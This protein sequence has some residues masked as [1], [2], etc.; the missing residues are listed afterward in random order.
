ME[1]SPPLTD[2]RENQIPWAEARTFLRECIATRHRPRD[3]ATLEDLTQ[4]ALVRL[5]RVIRREEV[6]NMNGLMYEIARRT[7][8][9]HI[10]REKRGGLL[11][12]RAQ[13]DMESAASPQDG[14][15]GDPLERLRFTILEYFRASR[16]PCH[17][18]ALVFFEGQDWK[19]VAARM[20]RPYT[21]IRKQWSRCIQVLRDAL[22]SNP[23]WLSAWLGEGGE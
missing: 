14:D 9:D 21:A 19:T 7:W 12:Q 23:G 13:R 11:L 16:A 10:R 5:L 3:A 6:A 15:F 2:E 1:S 22:G 18:I 17:A 8:I 20:G 4:E